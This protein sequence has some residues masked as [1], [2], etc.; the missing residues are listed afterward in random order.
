MIKKRVIPTLLLSDNRLVKTIKFK[1]P[2]YIGDPLNVIRIFNQKKIDELMILDIGKKR[3]DEDNINYSLIREI[4]GECFMPL[5]YGGG[6]NN[7]ETADKLF[8]LGIEKLCLNK[9]ILYDQDLITK[10]SRKYG[11]QSIISVIN[12]KKSFLK[13]N[14]VY[15]HST[16]NTVNLDP[17]DLANKYIEAGSGEIMIQ[18]VDEE[19]T[20]N[21]VK[22]GNL[23][24]FKD[25]FNCPVI[26]S[27]GTK[28]LECIKKT[29]MYNY[30]AI[31][32][33][34]FF[35]FSKNREGVLITY[36]KREFLDEF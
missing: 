14:L 5:S 30:D 28:S 2:F 26:Y 7:I 9:S 6:I 27:G 8:S 23:S 17:F 21:G 12:I 36:P 3:F 20:M 4:A 24:L 32:V 16:R 11:S 34:S 19:G 35:T 13:K 18:F 1:K 22:D 29:F 25:K 31:S 33:G 15:D 10:I